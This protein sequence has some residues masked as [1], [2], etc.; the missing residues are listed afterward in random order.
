MT[1]RK[2][3]TSVTNLIQAIRPIK[4]RLGIITA[5]MV[6][7]EELPQE[8]LDSAYVHHEH[9]RAVHI[10]LRRLIDTKG[11][12]INEAA[13]EALRELVEEARVYLAQPEVSLACPMMEAE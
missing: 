3:Q 2:G 1:K 10:V 8:M 12:R 7:G 9:L 6:G 13:I 11:A 4:T 5:T